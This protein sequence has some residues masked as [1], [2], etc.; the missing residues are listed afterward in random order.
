MYLCIV[1]PVVILN[2]K[3]VMTIT[4]ILYS[5]YL[6]VVYVHSACTVPGGVDLWTSHSVNLSIESLIN[7]STDLI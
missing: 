5:S 2:C 4:T 1:N 3:S 7:D 6:P